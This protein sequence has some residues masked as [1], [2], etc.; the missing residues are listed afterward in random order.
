MNLKKMKKLIIKTL[1]AIV[2]LFAFND[3]FAQA[4]SKVIVYRKGS[5]YGAFAK[6][7]VIV[8]GKQ[9]DV[10]KGSSTHSYELVPGTHT[11][12]PKQSRRAITLNTESGKT[13]VVKYRNMLGL[14]GVRPKLKVLTLEEAKEDA[15]IVRTTY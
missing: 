9:M 11:I 7:Q 2:A 6:Y 5:P 8:D 10:L 13:Y 12:S 14:F 15:K 3:G 1:I 4:K